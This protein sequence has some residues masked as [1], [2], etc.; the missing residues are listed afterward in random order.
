MAHARNIWVPSATGVA[1][2]M[3]FV[4][5]CSTGDDRPHGVRDGGPDSAIVERCDTMTD[6]DADGMFDDFEGTTDPDGDGIAN[7]LDGDSDGD[8][9]NDAVE[10]GPGGGCTARNSDGDALPDY[11][12]NDSDNDGL[13]DREESE[14]YFTDP[15]RADSDGDG[16]DD[17]SEVATMH[18]PLDMTSRLADDDFY[19]VLPYESAAVE[20]DLRFGSRVRKADVFFMMDRTGSM[21]QEVDALRAGLDSLVTRI[22][23]DI[24]DIGVGVGGFSDFPVDCSACCMDVPILGRV[25]SPY[26]V[27]EDLPFTLISTITTD[28]AEMRAA[29][30]RLRADLGGATWA[31]SN[32]ALYQ[33]ATGEGIAPWVPP[34]TCVA[35]PDEEGMRTGYPCFRPG[36]LPIMVVLTD[37]S[38]RNGPGTNPADDYQ[39]AD[40]SS[41]PSRPHTY[42]QTLTALGG[43]GARVFGVISGT[44]ITAPTPAAQ[45]REWATMTGTIDA[46]GAP[47]FF[48]ISPDG[49]GLTDSVA[50]AIRQLAGETPQDINTRVQDGEDFPAS[51]GPVDAGQFIKAITPLRAFDMAGTE[52]P[53]PPLMRDDTTFHSVAPGT[54]LEFRVRFLNDFQPPINTA[55]VFRAKIFV[56]GNGVADLDVHEVVIVVP[57]GSAPLI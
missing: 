1:A 39:D 19:V 41:F 55:Q 14:T 46:G 13:G 47:I 33:A 27:A 3:L 18:D 6:A 11:L 10:H 37:T 7:Y 45:F 40:F 17:L 52:I 32:E 22:T 50:G 31:S 44:E 23:A 16:F 26:G 43:I 24:P 5:S 21:T 30:G 25:C 35:I 4:P 28:L 51:V 12:D 36:A 49:T 9:L 53:D 54:T 56:V 48:M 57:A 42:T 2:L 20:R 15:L 34:Q 38:S 8:G 29:V